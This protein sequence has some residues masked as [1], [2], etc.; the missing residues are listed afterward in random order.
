[1]KANFAYYIC[2]RWDVYKEWY[3][4][5]NSYIKIKD[6]IVLVKQGGGM[7]DLEG[8]FCPSHEFM[9][10]CHNGTHKIRGIRE[11]NVWEFDTVAHAFYIHPTQKPV[12]LVENAIK[13]SSDEGD[14][15]LDLFCGSGTSLVACEN[16]GRIGFGMEKDPFYVAVTLQRFKNLGIEV[17]L[18]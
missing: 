7:G 14:N 5:I 15:V 2:T 17:K 6:L 8:T 18:I 9:M 4:I 13:H 16:T 1:M 3:S 10:F 11:S 12:S